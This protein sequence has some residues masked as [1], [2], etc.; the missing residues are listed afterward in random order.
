MTYGSLD[1]LMSIA[2]RSYKEEFRL[3]D[4]IRRRRR[5]MTMMMMT[6]SSISFTP[7]KEEE[8]NV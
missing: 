2:F 8:V 7:Y 5:V 4:P 1:P 3:S 6:T